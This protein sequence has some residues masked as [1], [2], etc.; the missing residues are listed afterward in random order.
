MA[1]GKKTG[2][3]DFSATHQPINRGRPPKLT[4]QEKQMRREVKEN[5][6]ECCYLLKTRVSEIKKRMADDPTLME[7]FVG[8]SMEQKNPKYVE[9]LINR[10][11]GKPKESIEITSDVKVEG[12]VDFAKLDKD[13]LKAI[14]KILKLKE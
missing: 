10:A 6:I 4:E 5:L 14:K 1:R 13:Q 11:V 8:I 2:G 3:R 9:M 7:W 12:M